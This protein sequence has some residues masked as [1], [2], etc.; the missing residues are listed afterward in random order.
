MNKK[1]LALV[2][3]IAL[4]IGAFAGLS[5]NLFSANA[6]TTYVGNGTELVTNGNCADANAKII[7]GGKG[8]FVNGVA[9]EP[10][11]EAFANDADG[12]GT[13][14]KIAPRSG[15]STGN[16]F[17]TN[18]SAIAEAGKY[19]VSFKV[20]AETAIKV[21]A[22]YGKKGSSAQYPG[23]NVV[24]NKDIPAN[25]WTEISYVADFEAAE[26][27][28]GATVSDSASASVAYWIAVL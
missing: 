27:H 1:T 14:L 9:S 18:G 20:Y 8:I 2:L 4:A 19:V 10:K 16:R 17:Y 12:T 23:N 22:G 7:L 11:P 28:I 24:V 21:A 5:F 3:A 26:Y 25:T 15:N 6:E 13:A